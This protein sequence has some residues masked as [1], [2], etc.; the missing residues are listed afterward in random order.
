MLKG[1]RMWIALLLLAGYSPA[2]ADDAFASVRQAIVAHLQATNTPS[3][4]VGITRGRQVLWE[5][6]FGWADRERR[7]RAT[8]ST[9][10][11]LAS[12]T[13]PIT[14]TALMTLVEARKIDLDAPVNQYLGAAKLVAHIG[15]VRN[16][17]VR[18]I[19]NHSG[20]LP[21]H[22]QFFYDNEPWRE[23]SPDDV[24]RGYG[25]VFAPPGEHY[26]YSNLG[27][28]ILSDVISRV[29]REPFAAYVQ[30]VVFAPLAM[31]RSSI[32]ADAPSGAAIRYGD[33]GRPVPLY[34]TDHEGA[35]AAWSS[36]DDLIRFAMFNLK[37]HLPDQKT[38]LSDADI[39][40][41][42]RPTADEGNGNGD[43]Y[44]LGWETRYRSGY[45]L[46][47]HTGDMPGVAAV[48]RTV[49][50]Q[51]VAVV[52]LCNA[53]DFDFA[54]AIAN[55]ALSIVL[56]RW[57]NASESNRTPPPPLPARLFGV[58]RGSVLVRNERVP[59]VLAIESRTLAR[60]RIG[61]EPETTVIGARFTTSGYFRGTARGR[62]NVPDASRRP[63]AL[64]FRLK[65]RDG[66]LRLAG[67]I[68]VRADNPG[69]ISTT[70]WWPATVGAPPSRYV[71]A[72]GFVLAFW[73]DLHRVLR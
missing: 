34:E 55:Q 45:R 44:G 69:V 41:L 8:T 32:G 65:L 18:R 72:R 10:Y 61:T 64:G 68:T 15:D 25:G 66:D 12:D 54:D 60:V 31:T 11:S 71:Q 5:E 59:I 3:V 42:H 35:S 38:I 48:I 62:F 63:Y 17:T 58:W 52:V 40:E 39:D 30:Q 33:D 47:E 14:A 13:K 50:D 16:A 23:P 73:G 51:H 24:I 46:V 22:Y 4:V 70:G 27:Y 43:G 20:G 28:G 56:P 7:I 21:E 49:P 26:E 2:R 19:G 36:V 67:E 6:A 57:Q 9:P 53:E 29:S 37:L 1:A